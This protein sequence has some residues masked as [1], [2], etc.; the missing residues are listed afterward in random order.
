MQPNRDKYI[1]GEMMNTKIIKGYNNHQVQIPNKIPLCTSAKHQML[2]DFFI[3]S[4]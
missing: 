2:H 3:I 4:S 1:K